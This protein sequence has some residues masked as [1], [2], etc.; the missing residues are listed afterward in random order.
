[1]YLSRDLDTEEKKENIRAKAQKGSVDSVLRLIV[2]QMHN[3]V[4]MD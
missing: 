3:S 2:D 4:V 1:M